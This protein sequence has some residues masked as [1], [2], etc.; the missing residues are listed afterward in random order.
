M[1]HSARYSSHY[2]RRGKFI[3]VLIVFYASFAGVFSKHSLRFEV[4]VANSQFRNGERFL[5]SG[6]FKLIAKAKAREKLRSGGN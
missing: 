1:I 6:R 4:N 2:R 3:A 5:D